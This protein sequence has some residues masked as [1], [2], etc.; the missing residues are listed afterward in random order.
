MGFYYEFFKRLMQN[1][2]G[3]VNHSEMED[4]DTFSFSQNILGNLCWNVQ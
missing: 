4:V 2:C 3:D 1:I